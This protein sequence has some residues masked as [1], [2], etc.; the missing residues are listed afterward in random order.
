MLRWAKKKILT[1]ANTNKCFLQVIDKFTNIVYNKVLKDNA[2]GLILMNLSD[3]L[4]HI[5]YCSITLPASLSGSHYVVSLPFVMLPNEH[6][7]ANL[8]LQVSHCVTCTWHNSSHRHTMYYS[9]LYCMSNRD[10]YSQLHN[11]YKSTFWLLTILAHS[12]ANTL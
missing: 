8:A 2:V 7:S 4:L 12:W 6:N 11:S 10:V 1:L 9:K 5:Q 3:M